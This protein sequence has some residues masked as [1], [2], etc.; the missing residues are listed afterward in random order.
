MAFRL[1]DPVAPIRLQVHIVN[2]DPPK[3]GDLD[4]LKLRDTSIL[5]FAERCRQTETIQVLADRIASRFESIH[6]GRG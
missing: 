3:E 6:K 1:P 5:P 4:V 2:W